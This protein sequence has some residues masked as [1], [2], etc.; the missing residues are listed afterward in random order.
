M[1]KL[2]PLSRAASIFTTPLTPEDFL[3]LVN[4]LASSRQLR[5]IVTEV[6][7]ETP[8]AA[9]I[10]FRP[11]RGW[12][13][14]LAGQWARIGVEIDGVRQ[15]RSYSLSA[16]AGADP[17]IT[18]TAIGL[19]STALVRH[20]A[21]GDVLFLAPPQGEFVLPQHPRPLLML[22]AG[23][24]LTPVMSMIRTLIPRRPD[25]DVVLLHSART[26]DDTLFREELLELADQF[27]GLTVHFWHTAERGRRIGLDT[28]EDI[29]QVCPDWRAR[30]AYA[31]GPTDFLDAAEALW[32][33][34]EADLLMERFAR[35]LL[36]GAGGEGGRITF[37]KSDK[38]VEADGETTILDAGEDAGVVMPSGCR[39]GICRSCLTPLIS[40][41]LRDLRT[42]EVHGE[43]GELVQTC[44]NAAAGPVHLD[45]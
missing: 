31:C 18:V 6:T 19:V 9:T 8:N 35:V 43:E 33:R 34:E 16:P 27:P 5:G 14:H 44:V 28:L 41:Q 32:Q 21:P 23:S 3:G 25:A 38:E 37:E 26:P 1:G 10:R 4:P 24:G 17:A 12:D 15:W 42:G 36:E 13:P 30:A 22:T 45:L 11:G 7:H 39:M 40:G 20:T 2:R 29:E